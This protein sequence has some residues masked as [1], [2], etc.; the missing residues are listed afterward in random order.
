MRDDAP[1][2][3][4]PPE[5]RALSPQPSESAPQPLPAAAAGG[6][7][8]WRE[9]MAPACTC[10]FGHRR[11][12]PSRPWGSGQIR[13]SLLRSKAV[14]GILGLSPGAALPTARSRLARPGGLSCETE[15]IFM[16]TVNLATDYGLNG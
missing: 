12:G 4:S 11:P 1:P 2:A 3:L 14:S 10:G 16:D 7:R 13:P 8:L 5:G 6:A 15:Q 9:A